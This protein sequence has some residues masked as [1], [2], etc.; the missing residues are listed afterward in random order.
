MEARLQKQLAVARREASMYRASVQVR[1]A[2][3]VCTY[4]EAREGADR[5]GLAGLCRP[6][7]YLS[8]SPSRLFEAAV[9]E[10]T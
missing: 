9:A 7:A 5:R 4:D 6:T 3:A 10:L 8:L 2:A 1:G